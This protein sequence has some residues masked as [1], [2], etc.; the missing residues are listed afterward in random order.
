MAE[1]YSDVFDFKR[2]HDRSAIV[3]I[4]TVGQGPITA[5]VGDRK[6]Y[7]RRESDFRNVLEAGRVVA[8]PNGFFM[9][10]DRQFDANEQHRHL[11]APPWIHGIRNRVFGVTDLEHDANHGPGLELACR[12]PGFTALIEAAAQHT[13]DPKREPALARELHGFMNFHKNY[14]YGSDSRWSIAQ[15]HLR[16]TAYYADRQHPYALQHGG[17]AGWSGVIRNMIRPLRIGDPEGDQ[18]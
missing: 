10:S 5:T 11:G 1:N 16:G 13:T 14:L 2:L 17:N 15:E 6:D 8:L 9:M 3:D 7:E 18:R 4:A 12:V